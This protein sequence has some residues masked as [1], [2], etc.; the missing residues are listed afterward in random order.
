MPSHHFNWLLFTTQASNFMRFVF[1]IFSSSAKE[2][3]KTFNQNINNANNIC[4]AIW[5]ALLTPIIIIII[6]AFEVRDSLVMLLNYR[7]RNSFFRRFDFSL[8][9][10]KSNGTHIL[11]RGR[12]GEERGERTKKNNT[13]WRCLAFQCAFCLIDKIHLR[14]LEINPKG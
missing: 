1:V 13:T 14:A 2:K 3:I 6:I 5:I 11:L 4:L 7:M 9:C 8:G 12:G 10:H